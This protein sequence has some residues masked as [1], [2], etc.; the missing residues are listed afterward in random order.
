MW[1]NFDAAHQIGCLTNN[2]RFSPYRP[3]RDQAWGIEELQSGRGR[4]YDARA[5]D[6]LLAH[7]AG[8]QAA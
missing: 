5:V 8:K 6:A 2:C 4:I 7:L 1:K 3:A